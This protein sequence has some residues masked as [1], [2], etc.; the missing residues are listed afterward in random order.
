MTDENKIPADNQDNNEINKAEDGQAYHASKTQEDPEIKEEIL[1]EQEENTDG[2]KAK[3]QFSTKPSW[4]RFLPSLLVIALTALLTFFATNYLTTGRFPWQIHAQNAMSTQEISKLQKTFSLITD[5]YIGDVDREKLID[6]ALKGMTEAVDDPY[7]TYLHGDESSQLD[8]TI[9]ANFEGIGAQITVRDNQIVVISPIKG[10]PA[11]KAGIQTDDIIKSVNGESLEGKN[12]QE[13][14]NMIRGEAG[15]QVQLVIERGDDQQEL[16]LTR[17]EIPL[18]TVYSHQIEG[19]PE[20]G[21]IQISSF[22]EPTAKD[23]QE[24]VKSMRDKGVKSFIF[25]VRG[26]PGGLLSSAIQIS[27]YF[28]ADGDTIVQIEDSQGNRKKIQADKSKMGDFKIDEPSVILIDKGSA[29]ASEILAGALQQSAHIP[30][31]GSQSFGKGTVQ[32]VVKLDDKDQLKITY[33]HWLT[34]D[35]SW[36]HKQGISPDIEAQLPDYSELS[37]VDGSQN[38]QLGEESDKIKNIQA[39]LALLGYLESDQVQGKFDEQTQTALGAFQA[40]HELEKTGQVNDETAQA[41]TR[42]LRDY[43]LAHDTQKDK[44]VDYLLDHAQ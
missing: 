20:I 2:A 6:G 7:T 42:A 13:A 3:G 27:N 33:A 43:I 1:L 44:A 15:S 28:L 35:G 17:A 4:K 41:L 19:H 12:A 18:Q 23:V 9:E 5:G 8:Q 31:I 36:I 39:Q 38:Y 14:A 34:P 22:S 29:S 16:S 11:E 10:S 32:T 21:L 26:N 24:T 30:V 37:L 40:D 25:D